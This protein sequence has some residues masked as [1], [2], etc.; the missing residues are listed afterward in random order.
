MPANTWLGINTGRTAYDTS[1]GK[2]PL[3]EGSF[4][5]RSMSTAFVTQALA[6]GSV[7][8]GYT[9]EVTLPTAILQDGHRAHLG[10][11]CV[12]RILYAICVARVSISN[13]TAPRSTASMHTVAIL[14]RVR[15][16]APMKN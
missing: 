12:M 14:K 2:L 9:A 4:N 16:D 8:C 11:A 6:P 3:K 15:S 13:C 10:R 7:A 1:F 5:A